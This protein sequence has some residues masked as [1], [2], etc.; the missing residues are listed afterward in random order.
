MKILNVV[1]LKYIDL[2]TKKNI[3]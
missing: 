3:C 1:S 2:I